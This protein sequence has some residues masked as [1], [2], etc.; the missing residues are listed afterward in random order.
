MNRESSQLRV[1][2]NPSNI[3]S[4]KSM[5]NPQQ[6]SGCRQWLV[7]VHQL[8]D[9]RAMLAI[10]SLSLGSLTSWLQN[11]LQNLGIISEF[12]ARSKGKGFQDH[13]TF[14]WKVQLFPKAASRI[15][16]TC[17]WTKLYPMVTLGCER[18]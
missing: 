8:K 9:S 16:F 15:L 10:L 17:N 2:E 6:K 7:S 13:Y 12:K 11:G 3:D 14:I 1:T 18:V 5:F 4:T